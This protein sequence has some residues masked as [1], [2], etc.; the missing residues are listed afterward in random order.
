MIFEVE[1]NSLQTLLTLL[2]ATC[3]NCEYRQVFELV[4]LYYPQP[5]LLVLIFQS[6]SHGLF[7]LLSLG[8]LG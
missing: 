5:P 8:D 1:E 2:F 4:I 3:V 6:T 7:G